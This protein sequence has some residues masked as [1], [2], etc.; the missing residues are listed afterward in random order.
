[1]K[2]VSDAGIVTSCEPA[3]DILTMYQKKDHLLS[4]PSGSQVTK[5]TEW[6]RRDYCGNKMLPGT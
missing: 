4:D 5:T 6:I 1:M 3:T 2:E